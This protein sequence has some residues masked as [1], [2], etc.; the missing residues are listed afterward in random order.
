MENLIPPIFAVTVMFEGNTWKVTCPMPELGVKAP[1]KIAGRLWL[2]SIGFVCVI[3]NAKGMLE[4]PM[5]E[6]VTDT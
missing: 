4:A 5:P 2:P 1:E 6:P 3:V